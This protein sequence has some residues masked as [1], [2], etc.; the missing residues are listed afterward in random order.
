MTLVYIVCCWPC[1]VVLPFTHPEVTSAPTRVPSVC[2]WEGLLWLRAQPTNAFPLSLPSFFPSP[3]EDLL[4]VER[5]IQP[6]CHGA[7]SRVVEAGPPRAVCR[8]GLGRALWAT[9][10]TATS[11][12][13][14]T[15]CLLQW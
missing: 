15:L 9:E 5:V 1:P 7:H 3:T 10:L 2:H 11:E 6:H 12:V 13:G 14:F 4:C 8:G